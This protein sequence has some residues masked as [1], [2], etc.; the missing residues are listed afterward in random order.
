[1]ILSLKASGPESQ[2]LV[3]AVFIVYL[4][5]LGDSAVVLHEKQ[6]PLGFDEV[7]LEAPSSF[8]TEFL[9]E[10]GLHA[11]RHKEPLSVVVRVMPKLNLQDLGLQDTDLVIT[12]VSNRPKGGQHVNSW[13]DP[14]ANVRYNY[15]NLEVEVKSRTFHKA[16][17]T[18]KTIL[19]SMIGD[20]LYESPMGLARVYSKPENNTH[21]NIRLSPHSSLVDR[22]KYLDSL[23]S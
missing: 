2:G 10:Y 3:Y 17:L 23:P 11:T 22:F 4:T 13:P 9:P 14:S 5:Y 21:A 1:M 19:A 18:A 16:L 7:V 15:A 20:P 8:L 6:T 12:Q